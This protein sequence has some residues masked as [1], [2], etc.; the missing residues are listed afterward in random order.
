MGTHGHLDQVGS[1][2]DLVAHGVETSGRR[3]DKDINVL[4][5]F[6]IEIVAD[7]LTH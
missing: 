2:G 5:T 3:M 4:H 6:L 1:L 7:A